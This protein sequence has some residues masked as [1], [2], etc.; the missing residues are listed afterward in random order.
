MRLI[1]LKKNQILKGPVKSSTM[2]FVIDFTAIV[3]NLTIFIFHKCGKRLCI[4]Y[5]LWK[6]MCEFSP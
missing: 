1:I 2:I 4:I 3:P 5:L 6:V